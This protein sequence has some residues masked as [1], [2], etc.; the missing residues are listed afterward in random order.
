[1]QFHHNFFETV[2]FYIVHDLILPG[3]KNVRPIYIAFPTL[4]RLDQKT[5]LENNTKIFRGTKP[6]CE[7]DFLNFSFI[8][9]LWIAIANL[10][11]MPNKGWATGTC[12]NKN[13]I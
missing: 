12:S 2:N 1:M 7:S 3:N 11:P 9:T 5:L 10:L 4:Y 13:Q 8:K 6:S